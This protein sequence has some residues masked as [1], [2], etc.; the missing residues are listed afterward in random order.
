MRVHCRSLYDWDNE[1]WPHP[2]CGG[3]VS[4]PS[5]QPPGPLVLVVLALQLDGG[6]PDL[7]AVRVGLEGQS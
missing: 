6:Q 5:Q 2:G 1:P 7:L 3:A 4:S